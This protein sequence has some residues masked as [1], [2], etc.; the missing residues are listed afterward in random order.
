MKKRYCEEFELIEAIEQGIPLVSRPYAALAERIGCT[1]KQVIQG[2]KR[3]QQQG[4]I[5]RFGVVVKHRPLGY[6]ANGMVVWNIPETDIRQFGECF[7]QFPWVTLCYQRPRQ[8]P[9]WPY[10][11]FT[12]VHGK[13]RDEVQ[14]R[15]Q[16]MIRVCRLQDIEFE[17]LFSTR[18][19][20]QRGARYTSS[21]LQPEKF[22][23][24]RIG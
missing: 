17:I 6:T 4:N 23:L 13:S 24:K 2:I 9:N 22:D 11:L 14:Q 5:K 1:E 12:M 18:C 20:K 8:L 7:A 21:A 15:T 10:N 19:F 3:L 16:E